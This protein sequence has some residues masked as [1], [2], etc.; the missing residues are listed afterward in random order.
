M[1]EVKRKKLELFFRLILFRYLIVYC[2]VWVVILCLVSF[3]LGGK[4]SLYVWSY[5]IVEK[6]I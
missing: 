2:V 5:Y 3:I 1:V 6:K 4:R